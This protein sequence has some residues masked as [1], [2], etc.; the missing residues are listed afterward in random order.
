MDLE[1][2]DLAEGSRD[3]AL[4][5]PTPVTQ[6]TG[7]RKGSRPLGRS[8]LAPSQDRLPGTGTGSNAD[9]KSGLALRVSPHLIC[10]PALAGKGL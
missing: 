5:Q 10:A 6:G 1:S 4:S 9:F 7:N 8:Q 2:L 3:S